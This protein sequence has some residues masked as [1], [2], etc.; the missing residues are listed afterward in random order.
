MENCHSYITYSSGTWACKAC[1]PGYYLNEDRTQC[2]ACDEGCAICSQSGSCSLCLEGYGYTN[3]QCLQ[4]DQGCH[5]CRNNTCLGCVLGFYDNGNG[6]CSEC[7]AN[8]RSCATEFMCSSCEPGFYLNVPVTPAPSLQNCLPCTPPCLVC[9]NASTCQ[10]CKGGYKLN[11]TGY[12]VECEDNFLICERNT[13]IICKP[14]F[15]LTYRFLEGVFQQTCTACSQGCL[16][17][18][19]KNET[20]MMCQKCS[21]GLVLSSEGVCFQCDSVVSNCLVC[22]Q[23]QQCQGCLPGFILQHNSCHNP[24][25]VLEESSWSL[26]GASIG[27]GCL[28]VIL[29]STFFLI[30]SLF[31]PFRTRGQSNLRVSTSNSQRN[32]EIYL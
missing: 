13:G 16:K 3:G 7:P 9:S 4:C 14:G 12:C 30:Q 6:K 22:D 10:V 28:A 21:S 19:Q 2:I 27:L 17:C 24:N 20:A 31:W 11:S 18:R 25:G 1:F 32:A 29:V 15:F 26:I 5:T 8:C 23:N